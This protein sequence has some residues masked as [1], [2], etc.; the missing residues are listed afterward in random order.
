MD[1][2]Y[3]WYKEHLY[4]QI[5]PFWDAAFDD[6]YGGVFTCYTNDGKHRVSEDKYTWSQGRMLWCLSYLLDHAVCSDGLDETQRLH[7][8]QRCDALYRLLSEHVLLSGD[9]EVC[10]FLLDRKGVPKP[11]GTA[12]SLYTSM[13]ADCFVI[14]G[15]ARYALLVKSR[16]IADQ[17]LH[18]Y[19]KM[20]QV[21]RRGII[22]TEPYVLSDGCRAQSI[23]MIICNTAQELAVVLENLGMREEAILRRDAQAAAKEVLADFADGSTMQIREVV[24]SDAGRDASL[25]ARHRNPGH[26]IECMW[27]CLDALGEESS[28]KLSEYVL[29][30]LELGWDETWGGLLRYVDKDGRQPKGWCDGSAFSKLVASTWDMK[31]WWPHVEALYACARFYQATG[32]QR[33]A[34]WYE[35]LKRYTYATFPAEK[36]WEWIQI[37]TRTGVPQERVVALGVKDPY[38]ILRMHLLMLKM[39][40]ENNQGS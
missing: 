27:F 32:D 19:G 23:P 2:E 33:F 17:A 21:L 13:Y 30:S 10:A 38:H 16:E 1:N 8:R 31:L 7:Y 18:I 14:M 9:D 4:T 37:R 36:G 29:A 11:S 26:A 25:L 15:F 5:L 39:K 6:V 20:Q 3:A 28:S 35:R 34:L 40:A 22:K 12:G 24:F